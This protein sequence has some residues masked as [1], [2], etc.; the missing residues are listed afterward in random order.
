VRR[1]LFVLGLV[2]FCNFVF[3]Q[4]ESAVFKSHSKLDSKYIG[5][6]FKDSWA[7]VKD[8]VR[9]KGQDWLEAGLLIGGVALVY[10]QDQNIHDFIQRN[11]SKGSNLLS[12]NLFDPSGS[13]LITLPIL[14]GLYIYGAAWHHPETETF[15][16]QG[17]K[18][19]IISGV[20]NQTIKFMA[21]RHR[22]FQDL[23]ADPHQWGGPLADTK[24]TSFPSGHSTAAF[25][26]AT[27]LSMYFKDKKWVSW[28]SY[29]LAS[30]VALS[31]LN[32]NK[33]WASDVVAG[34]ILGHFVAKK[35][36]NDNALHPSKLSLAPY[37][38]GLSM[39]Y[40]L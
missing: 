33:H 11:R 1:F 21:H 36:F 13:G 37:P 20:F 30:G 27:Y 2:L 12:S 35:I 5:S 8:P 32:D 9:W 28:L 25:A 40:H 6:Y 24:Y 3:P 15:A 23:P 26:T 34:A 38:G 7:V 14:S 17:I 39:T 31:R 10:T 29:T 19:F 18:I 16:L 22:P 4:S